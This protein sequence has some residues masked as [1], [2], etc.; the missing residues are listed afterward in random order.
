[1]PSMETSSTNSSVSASSGSAA[2]AWFSVISAVATSSLMALSLAAQTWIMNATAPFPS[3]GDEYNSH[4]N[5]TLCHKQGLSRRQTVLTGTA[6]IGRA[7]EAAGGRRGRPPGT[8]RRQLELIA[9]RLFTD[10]GFD[11]TTIER[12]AAEAGVSK[13]TFFRYFSSK[14]SVLWSEFDHE[15]G[16]I[17]AAL[18]AVPPATEMMDAIRQAVVAANHYRAEDVP[19]LRARMNLIGTEPALVSSAATHYDA[20]ERAISDFVASRTGQP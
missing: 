19:E 8:S 2:G 6:S 5:V 20:W 14:A 16:T 15:V 3:R 11:S 4:V 12:I 9:L 13:R 1:M 18:A 10:Q 7:A 17:R